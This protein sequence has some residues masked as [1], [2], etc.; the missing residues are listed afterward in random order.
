MGLEKLNGERIKK[1][2]EL[3]Y[4]VETKKDIDGD[5]Y[6]VNKNHRQ[7]FIRGMEMALLVDALT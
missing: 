1:F 4:P 7:G 3:E 5:F 2:A 6:D